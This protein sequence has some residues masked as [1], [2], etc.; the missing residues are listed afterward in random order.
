[1]CGR[2]RKSQLDNATVFSADAW[3]ETI[4]GK[5]P[6]CGMC[7]QVTH[8]PKC[9]HWKHP[10]SNPCPRASLAHLA[11]ELAIA[12]ACSL[13][14]DRRQGAIQQ[15]I[16]KQAPCASARPALSRHASGDGRPPSTRS[17]GHVWGGLHWQVIDA[18]AT[19]FTSCLRQRGR[20]R[21]L[22]QAAAQAIRSSYVS[23]RSATRSSEDWRGV[24]RLWP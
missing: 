19:I 16:D 12:R 14:M 18:C 10:S 6:S 13:R 17:V 4:Q 11:E 20:R 1:M 21:C 7:L 24:F 5:R 23:A 22:Y 2:C 8:P 3:L 9:W 15:H